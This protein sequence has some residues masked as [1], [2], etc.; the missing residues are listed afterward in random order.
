MADVAAVNASPLIFLGRVDLLHLLHV[1]APDL[2]V[3]EPVWLEVMAKGAADPAAAAVANTEWLRRVPSLPIPEAVQAWDLGPGE[4]A[5]VAWALAREGTAVVIDD[6]EGRRCA[7]S[8]GLEVTGTLG[9]V[10]RASQRGIV[11]NP[12]ETLERLRAGG[13][14]LSDSVLEGALRTLARTP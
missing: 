6:L 1:E 12:R 13:M 5:V 14:W 2:V 7:L 11:A 3:P 4:S 8:L 10:L 9:L